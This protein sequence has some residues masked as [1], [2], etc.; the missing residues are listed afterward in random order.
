M[1]AF[2]PLCVPPFRPFF[3]FAPL[4]APLFA[5]GG[6]ALTTVA[7]AEAAFEDRPWE[8]AAIVA[9]IAAVAT[10]DFSA[11]AADVRC[12]FTPRWNSFVISS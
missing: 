10:V 2:L 9:V 7:T 3:V 12:A 6:S 4:F 11:A 1:F 5:R 8:E